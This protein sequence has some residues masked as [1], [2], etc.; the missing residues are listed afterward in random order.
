[1]KNLVILDRTANKWN[2]FLM[3]NQVCLRNSKYIVLS[4]SNKVNLNAWIVP[5][6]HNN[7]VGDYLS[8][9]VV[10]YMCKHYGIDRNKR[11]GC[12]KHLYTIGPIL[13]GY[14]DA[15]IWGSGFGY[16]ISDNIF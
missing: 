1:M 6:G 14:Q 16:N 2:R 15:T 9:V 5:N 12:T 3:K 4:E 11:I 13:L 8:V 7:N 10:E